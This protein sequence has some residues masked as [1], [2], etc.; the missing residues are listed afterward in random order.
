M[1]KTLYSCLILLL[2]FSVSGFCETISRAPLVEPP[3]KL[4][5][6]RPIQCQIQPIPSKKG[7]HSVPNIPVPK[8]IAQDDTP[9][10]VSSTN[11]TGYAVQK[12]LGNPENNAVG[13][14]SGSW[15][16]PKVK[17][18]G[19]DTFSVA[20]VGMDG[21]S[22][23]TVEQIGTEHDC[24]GGTAQYF[25]WFEMFP[26]GA[27]I[28]SG[29]PVNPGDVMGAT[30]AFIGNNTFQLSIEN[31]TQ[32]VF[33][34]VPESFTVM[35]GALRNSAQWI[36]EAPSDSQTLPLADFGT[37]NWTHCVAKLDGDTGTISDDDWQD[38]RIFMKTTSNVLKAKP[39]TLR[40]GGGSFSVLFDSSGP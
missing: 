29:F 11:W 13:S 35:P 2:T 33:F 9:P 16:V 21:F 32:G 1:K 24:L 6:L 31:F 5:K 14:V 28:L 40:Q 36:V 37:I 23:P 12:T 22:S 10:K 3:V 19:T 8:G 30:C 15:I 38:A 26:N 4:T 18:S 39:T 34:V 27:F 25:A 7:I 20:W 17:C